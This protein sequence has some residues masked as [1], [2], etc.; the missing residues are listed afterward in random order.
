MYVVRCE[1]TPG[2]P[3]RNTFMVLVVLD[4]NSKHVVA[5]NLDPEAAIMCSLAWRGKHVELTDGVLKF[6]E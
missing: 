2:D 5:S 3:R 4:D 1:V 6:L